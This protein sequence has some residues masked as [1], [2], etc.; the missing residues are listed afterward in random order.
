[1][2]LSNTKEKTN[3]E[4]DVYYQRE[5]ERIWSAYG[6]DANIPESNFDWQSWNQKETVSK[7]GNCNK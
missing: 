7:G 5:L 1:V 3:Y 2:T 6:H 4:S